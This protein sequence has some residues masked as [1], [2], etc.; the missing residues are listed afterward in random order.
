MTQKTRRNRARF[1][2]FFAAGLRDF[3]L[4]VC[5]STCA[6]AR[7]YGTVSTLLELVGIFLSAE[8]SPGTRRVRM[9]NHDEH[10]AEIIPKAIPTVPKVPKAASLGRKDGRDLSHL[11][12]RR[13][14]HILLLCS[15]WLFLCSMHLYMQRS[16]PPSTSYRL[17]YNT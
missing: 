14:T 5:T 15:R 3:V 17:D 2:A 10:H 4:R 11:R 7:A 8:N 9:L 12:Y 16:H 6:R 1:G 13:G